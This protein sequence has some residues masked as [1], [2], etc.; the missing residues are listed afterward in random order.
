MP[1]DPQAKAIIEERARLGAPALNTLT[2]KEARAN[3]A[4]RPVSSGPNVGRVENRTISGPAGEIPV[5]IYTPAVG[6]GPFPAFVYF[7]GGGWVI[8]TL[9]MSDGRCRYLC[10]D[11]GC[12]VVSVD[13]QLAP[14]AK[15]PLPLEECYAVT[16]WVAN[17]GSVLNVDSSRV[18]VGGDSA[19]GNLAA[20]VALMAR[21]R[22]GPTLVH[23][24]LIYPVTD[25]NFE[26]PSYSENGD[27]YLL[28]RDDM[29]WYW[30]QYLNDASEGSNPYA[31][32]LQAK[33]LGNLPSALIITAEYD[34]LRDEG[35][36]YAERLSEAGV[37][38][39]CTRYDGMIHGFFGMTDNID[40]AKEAVNQASK[41]L[42]EAF[43]S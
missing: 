7:H 25:L 8:G 14:E 2:P 39:V 5:R 37:P 9:D 13:Y 23:Q 30:D 22:Q 31:S 1:L 18:A 4:T 6:A 20:A 27:G 28:G 11:G 35:E 24:L 34:P 42:R 40:K 19:G 43:G 38:T 15:F 32:P 29:I 36:A 26:T 21:D 12:V 3:A 33:D 41:A 16:D 10:V 17:N